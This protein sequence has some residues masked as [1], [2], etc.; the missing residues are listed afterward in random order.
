MQLPDELKPRIVSTAYDIL[1]LISMVLTLTFCNKWFKNFPV[2]PNQTILPII[3]L[4]LIGITYYQKQPLIAVV[5]S[6]GMFMFINI[7]L[8]QALQLPYTPYLMP[9]TFITLAAIV[10]AIYYFYVT[11]SKQ[12]SLREFFL[13]TLIFAYSVYTCNTLTLRNILNDIIA[14]PLNIYLMITENLEPMYI[15]QLVYHTSY[16]LPVV[17]SFLFLIYISF[18]KILKRVN[19]HFIKSTVIVLLLQ[20][21]IFY[22]LAGIMTHI[23]LTSIPILTLTGIAL[24]LA[25]SSLIIIFLMSTFKEISL[26]RPAGSIKAIIVFL[27]LK[28]FANTFP[29]LNLTSETLISL[30]IYLSLLLAYSFSLNE[31]SIS[32]LFLFAIFAGEFIISDITTITTSEILIFL[33]ESLIPTILAIIAAEILSPIITQ[34]QPFIEKKT[35]EKKIEDAKLQAYIFSLKE[36]Y[37]DVEQTIKPNIKDFSIDIKE[38]TVKS[39]VFLIAMTIVVASPILLS[40]IYLP[41]K[42]SLEAWNTQTVNIYMLI[43]IAMIL[44]YIL[45]RRKP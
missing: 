44:A 35:E 24:D 1:I 42:M 38:I 25:L 34:T 32:K 26:N 41:I 36:K 7:Q 37:S 31:P 19:K 40:F 3:I 8:I 33:N 12:Q 43:T 20:F 39:T 11:K 5:I 6:I 13:T 27:T 17:P 18:S 4:A 10:F 22:L 30:L 21:I 29:S 45:W 28:L 15:N 23:F 2:N 9:Y 16:I 14:I